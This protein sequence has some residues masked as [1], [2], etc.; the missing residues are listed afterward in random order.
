MRRGALTA[1][2]AVSLLAVA[3]CGSE[4]TKEAK[5]E[6]VVGTVQQAAPGKAIFLSQGCGACH[7]YGPAG[8]AANGKIGP[9]LDKLPQFA[10]VAKQPLEQFTH[11]SIVDPDKYVQ[12]GFPKGV[13]P[14][15]YKS[16]PPDDLTALV[17]FLTK[18]QG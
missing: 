4:G 14:K 6:T 1:A 10:K 15:S 16:L 9:D 13:M 8:A 12:S 5:P 3:G 11:E 17:D 7:T 18:P 2:F